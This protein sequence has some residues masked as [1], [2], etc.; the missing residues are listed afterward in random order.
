MLIKTLVARSLLVS[1]YELLRQLS[2]LTIPMLSYFLLYTPFCTTHI[3]GVKGM[4]RLLWLIGIEYLNAN[5][6]IPTMGLVG[7][8]G[9]PFNFYLSE[10]RRRIERYG[11]EFVAVAGHEM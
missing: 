5:Q 9:E 4:S 1:H 6:H 7:D 3:T 2:F 8:E 10:I 11:V